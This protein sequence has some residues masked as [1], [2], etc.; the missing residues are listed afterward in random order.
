MNTRVH[1]A[2]RPDRKTDW[3]VGG[4]VALAAMATL[5]LAPP[6]A[7]AEE[8]VKFE[9]I[10]GSNVK[11][12]ILT[13]Q[14]AERLGIETSKV[15]EQRIVRKQMF[16]GQVIHPLRLQLIQK[17]AKYAFSSFGQAAA[18]PAPEP[19]TVRPGET[20][21]RLT[22]SEEEWDRVAKEKPARILPLAT[23]DKLAM[24]V[25]ATPSDMAPIEDVKRTMLSL[26]YVVP[27]G[28]HGL[29]VNDRMRV[30]LQLAGSDKERKVTPYSS[31]YYDG[32]GEPWVYVQK[33]PLVYERQ[34][35][36]V[37]R[38]VGE[39]VVLKDGPPVGT[40]VVIVGAALLYGAEVIYK[41]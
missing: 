38:I 17:E 11:R 24:E 30:E 33:K 6:V 8:P 1:V 13:A 9:N 31:L 21:V 35:V 15:S 40:D 5:L 41:K 10:P 36:E 37:E 29:N 2:I 19:V 12:V 39:Q 34:R 20:W 18:V 7:H 28:D 26:F 22:L 3:L 16:G 32:K 14:A 25:Y 4:F 27:E 23:R